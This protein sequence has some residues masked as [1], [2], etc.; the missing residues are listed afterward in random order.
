VSVQYERLHLV[1]KTPG[2]WQQLLLSLFLNWVIGPF[3]SVLRC[4]VAP[5]HTVS[6]CLV[7]LP[8]YI[9]S[10]LV[11]RGIDSDTDIDTEIG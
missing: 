10:P 11:S 7:T 4:S 2:L 1:F 5:P 8:S 9:V 6:P 3:V